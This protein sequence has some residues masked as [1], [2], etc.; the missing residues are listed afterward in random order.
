[1]NHLTTAGA[2]EMPEALLNIAREI[3]ALKRECGMDP[4]S[5]VAIQNGRYMTISH[6]VR[7][8]AAMLSAAQ[9]ELAAM[10]AGGEPV[11][12]RVAVLDLIDDCPGLSMEQDHW[13]SRRV[14]ELD[15]ISAHPNPAAQDAERLNKLLEA[16]EREDD[17]FLERLL[18]IEG[19]MT[20]EQSK[21][22]IDAAIAAQQGDSHE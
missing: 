3:E 19:P 22:A 18:V 6:K 11:A 7:N 9:A 1:M 15:F 13:L 20:V 5:P 17:K 14:K 12:W 4:E 10:R 16:I 8:L 2:A 21:A